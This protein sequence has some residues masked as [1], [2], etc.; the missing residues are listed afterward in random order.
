MNVLNYVSKFLLLIILIDAFYHI[1]AVKHEIKQLDPF[2]SIQTKYQ[3]DK[4]AQMK[5]VREETKAK[6]AAT[7]K[8]VEGKQGLTTCPILNSRTVI[9][10]S[11]P[12][13][14]GLNVKKKFQ[15]FS[16]SFRKKHKQ[17]FDTTEGIDELGAFPQ[18]VEHNMDLPDY[19]LEE[20]FPDLV[21]NEYSTFDGKTTLSIPSKSKD[22]HYVGRP[23]CAIVGPSKS[24]SKTKLGAEI[25]KH[26]WVITVNFH[27]ARPNQTE[28]GSR[29]THRSYAAS[30]FTW[31]KSFQSNI[32]K[33][34]SERVGRLLL[35]EDLK[36]HI[37]K[38]DPNWKYFT[39]APPNTTTTKF[40]IET[41]DKNVKEWVD[42]K[43]KKDSRFSSNIKQ[44]FVGGLSNGLRTILLFS[45]ICE[46]V[47]VY[48]FT[49]VPNVAY[50]INW[51]SF[52]TE[53][54]MIALGDAKGRWHLQS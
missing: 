34:P 22:P 5:T 43:L 41:L 49:P 44:Q 12:Y 47:N 13:H 24:L 21:Y 23:C 42:K 2:H 51:H 33:I 11:P 26:D 35:Y 3:I 38:L 9:H 31:R 32:A 29:L 25:D 45:Q 40:Y 1:Q 53:K 20:H 17:L 14:A 52:A 54:Y 15:F 28:W 36:E 10:S 8:E 37:P 6:V 50:G 30:M 39:I 4:L 19:Y 16:E 27:D 7:R 48:G 18:I 46:V